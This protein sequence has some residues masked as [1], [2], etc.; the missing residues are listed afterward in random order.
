M[1]S[2]NLIRAQLEADKGLVILAQE[3]ALWRIIKRWMGDKL[4]PHGIAFTYD[5]ATFYISV[6]G[7]L[8]TYLYLNEALDRLYGLLHENERNTEVP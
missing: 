5:A 8:E 3:S 4:A 7:E 1:D 6:R 2:N